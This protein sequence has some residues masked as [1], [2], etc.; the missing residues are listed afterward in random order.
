[1]SNN[2]LTTDRIRSNINKLFL[3]DDL[4][5]EDYKDDFYLHLD[6]FLRFLMARSEQNNE[7]MFD[8]RTYMGLEQSV[9]EDSDILESDSPEE[10]DWDFLDDAADILEEKIREL[11][12][13]ETG[14]EI[15]K[16]FV[17][18][19]MDAFENWLIYKMLHPDSVFNP[20][21][22]MLNILRKGY[23]YFISDDAD[24]MRG[25]L[26]KDFPEETSGNM[27]IVA[28]SG[29]RGE[30]SGFLIDDRHNSQIRV[31][32]HL[33]ECAPN[34]RHAR[35]LRDIREF[36]GT[37]GREMSERH[38]GKRVM[39]PLMRAGL[40]GSVS[41]GFFAIDRRCDTQVRQRDEAPQR[42]DRTSAMD[43]A[44]RFAGHSGR[45]A[46]PVHASAD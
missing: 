18:S 12:E 42:P 30:F 45:T 11:L 16:P 4:N 7:F 26:K 10:I 20:W 9:M 2:R 23:I 34:M 5:K 22:P 24:R 37:Q 29:R 19:T 39:L 41:K 38:I 43:K 17:E 27:G 31:C 8:R 32:H 46:G 1:M 25:Y 13:K 15:L 40:I 44:A 21:I 28:K 33:R 35:S 6:Q 36:L 14:A 3:S